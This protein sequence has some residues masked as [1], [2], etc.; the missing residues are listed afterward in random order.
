[1]KTI[2][3]ILEMK[4][5]L[6]VIPDSMDDALERV[7]DIARCSNDPASVYMA[8]QILINGIAKEL[9]NEND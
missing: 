4:S 1:M 2:N 9:E 3:K 8:V 5:G 7:Q 6:F